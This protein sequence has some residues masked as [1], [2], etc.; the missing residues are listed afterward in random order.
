MGCQWLQPAKAEK[1]AVV[2]SSSASHQRGDLHRE[3]NAGCFPMLQKA[4]F[5]LKLSGAN[6]CCWWG[7]TKQGQIITSFWKTV[8]CCMWNLGLFA[9]SP[10][11]AMDGGLSAAQEESEMLQMKS[12]PRRWKSSWSNWRCFLKSYGVAQDQ[13]ALKYPWKSAALCL[14]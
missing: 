7:Q 2:N 1:R 5:I 8:Q 6:W 12:V 13:G 11:Y 9:N 14:F 4:G 10:V 3:I